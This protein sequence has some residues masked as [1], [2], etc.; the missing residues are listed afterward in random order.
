MPSP[1]RGNDREHCR[2][3]HFRLVAPRTPVDVQRRA[4]PDEREPDPAGDDLRH[5]VLALRERSDRPQNAV[6]HIERTVPDE[7]VPC[8]GLDAGGVRLG[9]VGLATNGTG[10]LHGTM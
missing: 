10:Q 3:W 2:G 5:R 7:G 1:T 9:E 8:P 4:R 6:H